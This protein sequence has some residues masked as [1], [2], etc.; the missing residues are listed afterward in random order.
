MKKIQKIWEKI[1]VD[2]VDKM[3]VSQVCWRKK[4]E[5]PSRSLSHQIALI[6][7]K[8]CNTSMQQLLP[9]LCHAPMYQFTVLSAPHLCQ[10]INKLFGNT[11]LCII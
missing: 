9:A 10:E 11:M 7:M 8:E 5:I 2:S 6:T 1:L 3:A 4:L